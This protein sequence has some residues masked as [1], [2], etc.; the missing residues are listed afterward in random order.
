MELAGYLRGQALQERNLL[1]D[2]NK[3][4]YADATQALWNPLDAGGRALAAQ[5]FHHTVQGETELVADFIRLLERTFQIAYGQNGMSTETSDTFFPS[6]LQEGL[7]YDLMRGSA[8]SGAQTY[9]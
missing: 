7:W 9:V 8:V 5:N 6:Q 1:G 4:S 2:R 3:G